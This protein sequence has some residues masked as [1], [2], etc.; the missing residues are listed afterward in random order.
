[1][2]L[3]YTISV[4]GCLTHLHSFMPVM[5]SLQWGWL[6]VLSVVRDVTACPMPF[7]FICVIRMGIELNCIL[8]TILPEMGIL[9]RNVGVFMIKRAKHFGD[10][11]HQIAGLMKLCL[12]S[13]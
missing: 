6:K 8:G 11:K 12:F 13:M 4:F 3:C 2:V 7:S 5:S 10:M 1:M 9:N